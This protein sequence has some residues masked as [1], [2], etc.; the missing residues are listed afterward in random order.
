MRAVAWQDEV[1]QHERASYLNTFV[2]ICLDF[3]PPERQAARK[4]AGS[5]ADAQ[6]ARQARSPDNQDHY[7]HRSTRRRRGMAAPE[8]KC[9]ALRA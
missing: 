2:I 9:P 7:V 4:Q 5:R 6:G 8:L 3:G 1:V